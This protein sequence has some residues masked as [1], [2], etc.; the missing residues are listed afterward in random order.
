MKRIACV[1]LMAAA[2]AAS[3]SGALAGVP[4]LAAFEIA[5][6]PAASVSALNAGE[7]HPLW[8]I[9]AGEGFWGAIVVGIAGFVYKLARP[10]VV[11]WMEERKLARLYLAIEAYVA[12]NNADYVEGMKAANADGKLTKD[13]ADVVF[14]KCKDNLVL[15]MRSQGTDIIK[16]Y[17]DVFVDALI[18][19]LV[20]RLKNPVARAVAAPLSASFASA[21]LPPSLTDGATRDWTGADY[22]STPPTPAS[23]WAK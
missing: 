10:Y 4:P 17:G 6:T 21:P 12:K 13:E 9:L 22:G 15:F 23:D 5:D 2:V 3:L 7:A 1:L 14:R 19:L 16:E 18:E 20:S 11:A 8:L